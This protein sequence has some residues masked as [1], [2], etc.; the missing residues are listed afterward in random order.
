MS[1][2]QA[3]AT[4]DLDQYEDAYQLPRGFF[5]ETQDGVYVSRHHLNR[6]NLV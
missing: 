6:P 1:T 5:D 3:D 4:R 2:I